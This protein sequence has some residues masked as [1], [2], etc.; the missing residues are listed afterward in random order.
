MIYIEVIELGKK[1][2]I[3]RDVFDEYRRNRESLGMEL[4][5]DWGK[6]RIEVDFPK[7]PNPKPWLT[8]K[9]YEAIK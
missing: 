7:N 9:W 6:N 3:L 4:I 1:K 2:L 5:T 8:R